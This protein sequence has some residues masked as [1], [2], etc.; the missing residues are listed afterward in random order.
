MRNSESPAGALV[1]RPVP[2]DGRGRAEEWNGRLPA[3]V[4]QWG[5]KWTLAG[6]RHHSAKGGR[7]EVFPGN[8]TVQ[9]AG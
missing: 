8:R 4:W 6:R 5:L 7:S 1:W 9:H 3:D 2:F